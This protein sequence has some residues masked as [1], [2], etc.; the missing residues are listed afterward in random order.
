MNKQELIGSYERILNFVP[1]KE[2]KKYRN[3]I[4]ELKQ[5]DEPQKV[6]VP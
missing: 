1:L 5:L 4:K 3:F 6:Q 2:K